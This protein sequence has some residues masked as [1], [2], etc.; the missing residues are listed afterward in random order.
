MNSILNQTYKNIDVI[1]VDDG[2]TDNPYEDIK[3]WLKA[4]N[5]FEIKEKLLWNVRKYMSS[6]W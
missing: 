6:R 1:L 3:N 5:G 2:S 4:E